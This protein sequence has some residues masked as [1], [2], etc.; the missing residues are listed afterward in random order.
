MDHTIISTKYQANPTQ[1]NNI[2]IPTPASSK[3][4][5]VL[6]IILLDKQA[7][8]EVI[9]IL[10]FQGIQFESRETK[11]EVVVFPPHLTTTE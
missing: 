5:R 7:Y 9:R 8:S 3:K 1:N 10:T 6:P 11:P 4:T 2:P